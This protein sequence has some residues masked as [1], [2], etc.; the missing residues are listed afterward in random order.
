MGM[1]AGTS[2]DGDDGSNII[3]GASVGSVFLVSMAAA[4]M[5]RRRNLKRLQDANKSLVEMRE[6]HDSNFELTVNPMHLSAGQVGASL[7]PR[8]RKRSFDDEETARRMRDLEEELMVAKREN[9]QNSAV[10]YLKA[11]HGRSAHYAPQK[12]SFGQVQVRELH[13]HAVL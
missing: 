1:P 6:Q 7:S 4:L 13:A 10:E 8:R 12:K 2:G 11:H 3:I 9:Q 5:C